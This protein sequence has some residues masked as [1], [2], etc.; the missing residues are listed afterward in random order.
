MIKELLMS[1]LTLMPAAYADD[2]SLGVEE[3]R[4]K[5]AQCLAQNVYFEARNQPAAG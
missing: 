3:F 2:S 1:A 5:E 4:H